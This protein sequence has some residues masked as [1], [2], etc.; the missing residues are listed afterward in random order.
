MDDGPSVDGHRRQHGDIP[1]L[2]WPGFE[3]EIERP[4]SMIVAVIQ[5]E[6]S[7]CQDL[8]GVGE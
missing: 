8:V 2:S 4:Q 6:G 3:I 7:S 1:N 5:L